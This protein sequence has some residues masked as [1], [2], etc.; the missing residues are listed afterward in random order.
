MLKD[1][2]HVP[3]L[4]R[5]LISV[6]QLFAQ[7]YHP[8][9]QLDT[10]KVTKGSRI[11]AKG[12]KVGSLYLFEKPTEVGAAM[13]VV[14]SDVA[15]WHQRLGHMSKKGLEI[16]LKMD[17][18]PGLQ[19][20]NLEFCEHCLYGKQK[21]VSFLKDGHDMKAKPLELVHLDVFGPTEVSSLGGAKYFVTF[22]DCTRKVWIYMMANKSEVFS[23]FKVFKALVENKRGHKIKCLKTDN[24][25]E[26]CLLEFDNYCAD[27][28]IRRVKVV[29][30]NPQ[31]N[32]AAERLN[33]TILEKA[34][35]MLSNA[36]LGKEFWAEACNTTV[37]LIN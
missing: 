13:T 30:Y 20:A 27:N 7:G 8:H 22:L 24:G 36:G 10:W 6:S 18:L 28:G 32:R 33:R 23:K 34:R 9:F 25:G 12:N 29:P 14:S 19:L 2:C 21:R 16:M 11:I 5:N 37:Y 35:C 4:R 1:V 26:F 31:E 15:L 17:Q 3:K